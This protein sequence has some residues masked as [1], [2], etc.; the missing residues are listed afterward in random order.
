[1]SKD[2]HPADGPIAS[3]PKPT[4]AERATGYKSPPRQHSFK[5]GT[6]GNPRGRP[7]GSRGK[8]KIAENILL[9]RHE[10]IENGVTKVRTT[11]ELILLSLRQQAFEG[12]TRASKSMQ[13]IIRSIEQTQPGIKIDP[14]S[15]SA[16]QLL[17]GALAVSRFAK[18]MFVD[19]GNLI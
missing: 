4:S 13:V 2:K 16:S 18:N 1:M 12:D 3:A 6:S 17:N 10:V 7:K 11:L 8:R 19:A 5:K 14:A 15:R 9:E